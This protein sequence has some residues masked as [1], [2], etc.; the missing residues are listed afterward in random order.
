MINVTMIDISGAR[1][2]HYL[3]YHSSGDSMNISRSIIS[4]LFL[5]LVT[6]SFLPAQALK[7]TVEDIVTN[8]GK[9]VDNAVEIEGFVMQ[10][11]PPTASTTSYY[12]LK[13][14]YGS[15]IKVN[16]FEA[17]PD[18]NK[19]YRI[20][21]IV[22]VDPVS[23]YPFVSE[24]S[25]ISLEP[26]LSPPSPPRSWW[27]EDNHVIFVIVAAI[28]VLTLILIY[29]QFG[30]KRRKVLPEPEPVQGFDPVT[31]PPQHDFKTIKISTAI[32]KT[33][34]FIPGELVITSGQDKGKS[35]RIAGY[36]TPE[37]DVVTL[38]REVVSGDRQYAHIQL[39]QK[40]QTVS[41]KQAELINFGGK[42][43]VRNVSETNVTQ[44]DGLELRMGEKAELKPNS[45][46]RTG[47]LEFQYVIR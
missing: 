42:L 37:G 19:K 33:M 1:S 22:Y 35:F 29:L 17:A 20:T 40:F 47:E 24:K 3:I 6:I 38:G 46:M 2:T 5:L 23:K 25:K 21:G 43:F 4:L 36:P 30:R 12:I 28:V 45:T 32:P 26:V 9:F 44:V 16:T 34:K 13:G 7:T 27:E 39:D 18:I 41:R 31:P 14:S 8:P 10:Y 15:V 11:V